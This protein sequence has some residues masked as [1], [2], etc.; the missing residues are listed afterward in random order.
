[1][2]LQ[3]PE[4]DT[5]NLTVT[6]FD[7]RTYNVQKR[8]YEKQVMPTL[9]RVEALVRKVLG[10]H[11]EQECN[12]NWAELWRNPQRHITVQYWE[13]YGKHFPDN[14]NKAQVIKSHTGV[15][16]DALDLA[17]TD[18]HVSFKG[19]NTRPTVTKAGVV[20]PDLK[21]AHTHYL[22]PEHQE[23]YQ[24]VEQLAE[25]INS[26]GEVIRVDRFAGPNLTPF[27]MLTPDRKKLVVNGKA[28]N[29]TRY[30]FVKKPKEQA[31]KRVV[32]VTR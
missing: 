9:H 3:A 14:S 27:L 8:L 22:K 11:Y 29:N 21:D 18:Y 30:N 19:I 16:P 2:I 28:F 13:R 5:S 6:Y 25:A 23:I 1:M 31:P 12:V 10:P 24:K 26:L 15:H 17:I 4:K 7:E 32:N 20:L